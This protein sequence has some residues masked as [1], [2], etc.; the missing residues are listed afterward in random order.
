M[1]VLTCGQAASLAEIIEEWVNENCENID[2]G[3]WP[4]GYAIRFVTIIDEVLSYSK[5]AEQ[6]SR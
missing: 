1:K 4:D 3:Y 5:S 2:S 6:Q